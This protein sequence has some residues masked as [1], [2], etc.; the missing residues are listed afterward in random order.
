MR[1]TLTHLKSVWNLLGPSEVPYSTKQV[2]GQELFFAVSFSKLV[3]EGIRNSLILNLYSWLKLRN[4]IDIIR[5]NDTASLL[6]LAT[7][8]VA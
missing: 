2:T 7:N 6:F 1:I 5:N 8:W 3:L 4:P